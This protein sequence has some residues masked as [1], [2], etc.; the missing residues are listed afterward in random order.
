MEWK[1]DR[2][3]DTRDWWWRSYRNRKYFF[4]ECIPFSL[5]KQIPDSY[6]E[7]DDD[8]DDEDVS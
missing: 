8:A 4:R 2:L 5:Y 6:G 1:L 7:H 3:C